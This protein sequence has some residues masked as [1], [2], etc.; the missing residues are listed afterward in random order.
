MEEIVFRMHNVIGKPEPLTIM[1]TINQ[2]GF[3]F[4][5]EWRQV[6]PGEFAIRY[7]KE[8]PFGLAVLWEIPGFGKVIVT[9]DNEGKWY[10][11]GQSG[12]LDWRAEAAKSKAH[13]VNSRVEA[14]TKAGY[15]FPP[16]LTAKIE[17]AQADLAAGLG[18]QGEA[19]ARRLDVALNG[20]FYAAEEVELVKA[21]ADIAAMSL[22]QRRAKLF[23]ASFFDPDADETIMYRFAELFNFATTPFYRRGLEQVEGKPDWTPRDR[24]LDWLDVHQFARKGHPLSWWIE[25]G[26]APWMYKLSYKTMKEVV[27]Q[28]IFD[29][30][31]R[32]KDRIHVWDVINEAHDPIVK[33]NDLNLSI[34]QSLE[35]TALACKAT[36]DADPTATRIVN[37]NR[38]WGEYRSELESMDPMHAIEYLEELKRRNIDFE[39]VGVQMYHA[40]PEH[41][42]QDMAEQSWMMDQYAALG[43]PIHIS[44][45]QTPSSMEADPTRWL[46]GRVA[47]SG[48]WHRPWD[49]ETQADWVE[50]YYTIAVTKA[51]AI[52]WWNLSDRHTFWPHGGLLD[53]DNQPKPSYHRLKAFIDSLRAE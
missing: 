27:Y 17:K 33:G 35:I 37:I 5:S 13:R 10:R 46:G 19:G 14:L 50:Q 20:L 24:L 12:V 48:W 32:Y 11:L 45:V 8:Q 16:T 38:P 41:Y 52:T 15:K 2:R 31:T 21:R 39:V 43:K 47:P 1:H 25:H 49:L 44:E 7:P 18:M 26:L 40:G 42:V 51:D 22:E 29:T 4:F 9:A 34:E 23:G 36:H 28:Q 6:A 53:I 3:P 30:V